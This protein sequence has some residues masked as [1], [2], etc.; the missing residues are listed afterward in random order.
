M[1]RDRF[2]VLIGILIALAP[3][4]GLPYAWLD[5]LLP[6]LG[7]CAVIVGASYRRE[8]GRTAAPTPALPVEAA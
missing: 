1:S 4:S 8:R 2:L 3:F 7:V 6:A 5:W